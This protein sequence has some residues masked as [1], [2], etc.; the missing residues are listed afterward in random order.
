MSFC[1]GGRWRDRSIIYS[2]FPHCSCALQPG[3]GWDG[4]AFPSCCSALLFPCTGGAL[5]ALRVHLRGDAG[6]DPRLHSAP[7][8]HRP[9]SAGEGTPGPWRLLG[10]TQSKDARGLEEGGWGRSRQQPERPA[11]PPSPPPPPFPSGTDLLPFPPRISAPRRLLLHLPGPR[12]LLCKAPRACWPCPLTPPTWCGPP[13]PA[14]TPTPG[15]RWTRCRCGCRRRGTPAPRRAGGTGWSA[16]PPSSGSS[17]RRRSSSSKS[18][19]TPWHGAVTPWGA[20]GGAPPF[21]RAGRFVLHPR[22]P[23]VLP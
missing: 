2:V 9:C 4:R 14:G 7:G 16:S 21:P 12:A 5:P 22:C 23:R 19:P 17:T 15:H 13:V 11:V 10:G 18:C 6:A 3:A 8:W 20:A 1:S